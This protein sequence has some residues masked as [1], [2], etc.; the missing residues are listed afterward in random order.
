MNDIATYLDKRT[1]FNKLFHYGLDNLAI[2]LLSDRDQIIRFNEAMHGLPP[3]IILGY[4]NTQFS[5]FFLRFLSRENFFFQKSI[6][7][8]VFFEKYFKLIF[9]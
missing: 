3:D 1:S 2:E 5:T 4:H 8:V 7:Y 9:F 6:L